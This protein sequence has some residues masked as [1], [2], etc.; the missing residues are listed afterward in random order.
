[1]N[2]HFDELELGRNLLCKYSSR[3][4]IRLESTLDV[5]ACLVR[6]AFLRHTSTPQNHLAWIK[7]CLGSRLIA[8][9]LMLFDACKASFLVDEAI[10]LRRA[11]T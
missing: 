4:T 11:E 7:R 9:E 8:S 5:F 2:A 6:L 10:R 3:I 1:M